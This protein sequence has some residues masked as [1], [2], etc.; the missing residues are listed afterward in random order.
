MLVPKLAQPPVVFE[1]YLDDILV[2]A[3]SEA[4]AATIIETLQTLLPKIKLGSFSVVRTATYLD[5]KLT[6]V[7]RDFKAPRLPFSSHIGICRYTYPTSAVSVQSEL[8]RKPSDLVVL[9]HY[10]SNHSTAIKFG[11]LFGQCCRIINIS[12]NFISAGVNIRS[13]VELMISLR[14]FPT[15][16]RRRIHRRVLVYLVRRVFN[17]AFHN[18]ASHNNIH[19]YNMHTQ[20][21]P[22]YDVHYV[23]RVIG[24]FNSR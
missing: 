22:Y 7:L 13:L 20:V 15:M 21:H 16:S 1:S 14:G 4:H 23:S 17:L 2:V 24:E 3:N 18:L 8:Y 9:L 5:L 10:T 19:M 12:T 11:T 6:L